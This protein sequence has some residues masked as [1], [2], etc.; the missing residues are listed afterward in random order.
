MFDYIFRI[1]RFCLVFADPMKLSD[2][3]QHAQALISSLQVLELIATSLHSTLQEK[4][5]QAYHL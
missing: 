3:A 4:V 5:R 1:P 2:D